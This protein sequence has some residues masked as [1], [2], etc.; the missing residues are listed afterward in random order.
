MGGVPYEDA[1]RELLDVLPGVDE[2]IKKARIEHFVVEIR[3]QKEKENT[4]K[5]LKQPE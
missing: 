1:K 3:R 2:E 5:S 4:S